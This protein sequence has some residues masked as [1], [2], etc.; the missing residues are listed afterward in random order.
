MEWYK[1]FPAGR[2]LVLKLDEYAKNTKRSLRKVFKFLDLGKYSQI[3]ISRSGGDHFYK[4]EL[5]E[6]QINFGLFR[7]GLHNHDSIWDSIFVWDI[8]FD[9][10]K[11]SHEFEISEFDISKFACI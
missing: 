1:K 6:V 10:R 3:S 4:F 8:L 2:I 9:L 11:I 7:L 5:P